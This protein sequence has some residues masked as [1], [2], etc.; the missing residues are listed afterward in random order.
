[1]N[2]FIIC[3]KSPYPA[4]EGGPIAMNSIITGLLDAGHTVKVLAINTNKYKVRPDEIPQEF[5]D[6][7]GIEMAYIDLSIKPLA[8]FSNLFTNKSYHVQRFISAGFEEKLVNILKENTFDIIQFE[9]LYIA[10]YI[11]TIKKHSKAKIVLRAHNIEHLIWE[12]IEKQTKNPLKKFYLK[13]LARTLKKYELESLAKFDG[14]ATITRKDKSF[15]EK[16]TDTPLIDISFGIDLK[17]IPPVKT[18]FEFPSLFHIGAM[19]WI[20]NIEG[21]KWFL[22]TAWPIIHKQHPD[23]KF[24]LAGRE[25]PDWLTH[26]NLPNIV[27]LGE[28]DDAFHFIGSKGVMIVPLLS[29][30]GIRIKIIEGMAS[31][32]AIIAT[33]IGAEGIN[34][35]NEENIMIADTPEDFAN[36]VTKCIKS[37]DFTK[38]LG[39]NAH[40]LIEQDHDNNKIIQRLTTFYHKIL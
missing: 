11:D 39:N 1:M 38:S 18:E 19:N 4:K 2:V 36:A 30:S 24:Y 12:R 33:Q 21:I 32:K 28:V 10:P 17:R 35:T 8:A 40:H 9:T 20:P 5:H 26:T 27:V 23:L 34:Y 37:L 13:H 16:H 7:T 3:N 15:F 29:G 31:G 6:R 25:M 22:D 14:I